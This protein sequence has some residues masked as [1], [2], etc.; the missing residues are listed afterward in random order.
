[1]G[2]LKKKKNLLEVTWHRSCFQNCTPSSSNILHTTQIKLPKFL[3][4]MP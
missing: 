1:L 2:N 3:N 4:S